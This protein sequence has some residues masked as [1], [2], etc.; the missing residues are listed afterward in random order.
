AAAVAA[1]TVYDMV[2]DLEPEAAIRS[3]K[4]VSSSVGEQDAW[5][6][7]SEPGSGHKPPRGVRIAG[8]VGGG[9][10]RSPGTRPPTR[11]ATP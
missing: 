5:R 1:L 7:Q 9:S 10:G 8:R 11:R 4:L 2:R 3:I 6:R